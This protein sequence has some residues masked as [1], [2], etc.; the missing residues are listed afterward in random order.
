MAMAM[1]TTRP[2]KK[3]PHI[4]VAIPMMLQERM[5]AQ[6][7]KTGISAA[8]HT[9]RAI[10]EYLALA[11]EPPPLGLPPAGH[12]CSFY[13]PERML[14]KARWTAKRRGRNIHW[15][16]RQAVARYLLHHT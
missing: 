15:L 9:R 3:S 16:I 10:A 12:A 8:V 7:R 5:A 13:I 14:E 11:G 1:T 4:T 2:P 6:A